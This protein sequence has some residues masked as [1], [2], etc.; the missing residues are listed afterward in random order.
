MKRNREKINLLS[1]GTMGGE[2]RRDASKSPNAGLFGWGTRLLLLTLSAQEK[3]ADYLMEHQ[4]G[5]ERYHCIDELPVKEQEKNIG[6]D[7]ANKNSI[8]T[9]KSMGDNAGRVFI[10]SAKSARFLRHSAKVFDPCYKYE[11]EKHDAKDT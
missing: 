6:L 2:F 8:P 7:V 4:L 5:E 10:G 9:L 11:G 1:I 3:V